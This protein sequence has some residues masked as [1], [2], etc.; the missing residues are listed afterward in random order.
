MSGN[1]KK[2]KETVIVELINEART[3]G[4][5]CGNRYFEVTQPIMWNDK[6]G[7]VSLNHAI[8]MAKKDFLSHRGSDGST[9]KD[10]LSRVG[11]RWTTYGEN[12]SR[13]YQSPG[14]VVKVWLKS[15][16]HCKNMMNPNFK[17]AGS[18]YAKG[19]REIYWTLIL[20]SPDN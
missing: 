5:Q 6:L 17:E 13:G 3:K 9:V 1:F 8:D 2:G 4:V 19:S 18:A 16:D 14:E 11:Y 7:Q 12:V 20:A 10:R 15:K